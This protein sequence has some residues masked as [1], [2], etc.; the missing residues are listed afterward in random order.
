MQK[1][2]ERRRRWKGRRLSR[3]SAAQSPH[4]HCRLLLKKLVKL[5]SLFQVFNSIVPPIKNNKDS[6]STCVHLCVIRR[7]QG[8]SQIILSP[9]NPSLK[10]GENSYI[11]KFPF[12]NQIPLLLPNE[13]CQNDQINGN[14]LNLIYYKLSK[15]VWITLGLRREVSLDQ[16][17]SNVVA[18]V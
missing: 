9:L 13:T 2:I 7:N 15:C 18:I 5:K 14:V 4:C 16:L 17:S 1:E 10:T 12:F 8:F 11:G 3:P 6:F